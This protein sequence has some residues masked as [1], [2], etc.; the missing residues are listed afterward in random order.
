MARY[1]YIL[2]DHRHSRKLPG[3]QTEAVVGVVALNRIID[4]GRP[5]SVHSA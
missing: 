1:K 3:Q 5:D 4:V 2:G